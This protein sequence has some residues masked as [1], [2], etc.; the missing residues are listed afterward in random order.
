M[1]NQH[2]TRTTDPKPCIVLIG[3]PG[4]G[5]TTIGTALAN[6]LNWPY[7]DS[8]HLIE[9]TY[10]RRLQDVVDA[11]SNK[12]F[13]D[14]EGR[15][16][17]SIRAQRLVIG[18]GGSV[19]YREEAMKHLQKLG[20]II[21]LDVPLNLLTERIAINPERGIAFGPNQSINDIYKERDILYRK[22]SNLCCNNSAMS[23]DEC[24]T[25]ITKKLP[26]HYFE[27]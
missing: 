13:L 12:E 9:A 18:T 8:D 3:M 5:K 11:T 1:S 17:C 2:I 25:W 24:V 16:I 22:W 14:I 23:I 20:I 27:M 26:A 10:G 6:R 15:V 19:I 4:A 21:H 7:L